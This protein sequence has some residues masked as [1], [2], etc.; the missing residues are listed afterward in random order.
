MDKPVKMVV[1]DLDGTLLKD[2]A[3]I[4][5]RTKEAIRKLRRQG[6]L[7]GICS[8]RSTIALK[9]KIRT[10][11]IENDVD[12]VLGFNGA[13]YWDPKTDQ[14]EAGYEIAGEDIPQ[15]IQSC[16][17]FPFSFAEYED[18]K[19]LATKKSLLTGRMAARNELKFVTVRPQDLE[20]RAYKFMAVGM[21]WTVSKYLK[22]G[23]ASQL[24]NVRVFRSG[25]FLLEFVNENLS[26]LEGVK[27]AAQKHG[28]KLDEVVSF[29]NDNNDLEML[30][31][32]IGV[33]MA[34]ALDSVKKVSTF[35]TSSNTRDGVAEFIEKNILES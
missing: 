21:P 34:N 16:K 6:I 32:T 17:G 18:G 26:K 5:A 2:P 1:C 29:G 33:A 13:M 3:H 8:G 10:W 23:K 14:I 35:V 7:F 25:P 27:M 28:I 11:G 9:Q 12:F 31:G 30:E 15:I 22:S 24:K 20:K 19:M 4:S